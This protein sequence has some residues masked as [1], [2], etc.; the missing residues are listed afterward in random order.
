MEVEVIPIGS[1]TIYT[2]GSFLRERYADEGLQ[3][4]VS[5]FIAQ[6]LERRITDVMGANRVVI[7]KVNTHV[8]CIVTTLTLGMIGTGI[9]A[10]TKDYEKLRANLPL[11]LKDLKNGY[12]WIRTKT[13]GEVNWEVTQHSTELSDTD[14]QSYEQG[15]PASNPDLGERLFITNTAVMREDLLITLIEENKQILTDIHY[16]FGPT[17]QSD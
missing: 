2:G 9:F 7:L 13:E 14:K 10:V 5:M 6:L 3:L 11:I 16:T 4:Q 12:L 17:S 8:G 1:V 15:L